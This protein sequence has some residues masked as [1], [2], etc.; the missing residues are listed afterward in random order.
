MEAADKCIALI[1]IMLSCNFIQ[2]CMQ[3]LRKQVKHQCEMLVHA[4]MPAAELHCF[5]AAKMYH[6]TRTCRFPQKSNTLMHNLS[7]N[8]KDSSPMYRCENHHKVV[9][10]MPHPNTRETAITNWTPPTLPCNNTES[11]DIV[12]ASIQLLCMLP[13]FAAVHVNCC[14]MA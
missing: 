4:A 3:D 7:G 11:N 1:N 14:W 13:K 12:D 5:S 8:I 10:A 9:D 2:R 6:S